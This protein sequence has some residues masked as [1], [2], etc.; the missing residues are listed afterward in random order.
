M[1]Y[2]YYQPYQFG[3]Y[4]QPQPRYDQIGSNASAIPNSQ[5]PSPAAQ[6]QGFL[7]RPVTSREEA[8]AAQIDFMAAGTLMPDLGHSAVY[9]KRFNPNTGASDFYVFALEQNKDDTPVQYATKSDIE[10]L[11]DEIEKIKTKR[12]VKKNDDE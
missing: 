1:N 11:R 9:L 8:V 12:G 6:T 2:P 5:Q 3:A 4:S 10:A 7:V